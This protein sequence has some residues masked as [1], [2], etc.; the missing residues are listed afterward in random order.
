MKS[1]IVLLLIIACMV[2]QSCHR[3]MSPYE[4]ANFPKG[5]KCRDIK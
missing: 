2:F 1:R 3:A 5:K 4:A